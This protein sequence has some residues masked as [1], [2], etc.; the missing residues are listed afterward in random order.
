MLVWAMPCCPKAYGLMVLLALR[1]SLKLLRMNW[2]TI[3]P[4]ITQ[5]VK[6]SGMEF[7][8]PNLT[9]NNEYTIVKA[10]SRKYTRELKM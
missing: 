9:I 8:S 5:W 4:F 10:E 2:L 1:D 6:K 3:Y 7:V